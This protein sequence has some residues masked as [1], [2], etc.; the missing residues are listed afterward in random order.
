MNAEDFQCKLLRLR[1]TEILI[2][3]RGGAVEDI[4]VVGI[5]RQPLENAPG[6]GTTFHHLP[7][8]LGPSA[9]HAVVAVVV[10]PDAVPRDMQRFLRQDAETELQDDIQVEPANCDEVLRGEVVKG[11]P[12]NRRDGQ[13]GSVAQP[14]SDVGES[15]C[16]RRLSE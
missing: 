3:L 8:S 13:H 2:R 9:M 1:R 5:L 12:L 10:R 4:P 15:K 7:E 14:L 11:M 6:R 16:V